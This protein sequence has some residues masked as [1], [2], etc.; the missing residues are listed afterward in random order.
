MRLE[1][2]CV[3]DPFWQTQSQL[4]EPANLFQTLQAMLVFAKL[5]SL[6]FSTNIITINFISLI[7]KD[8]VNTGDNI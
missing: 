8:K 2:V 6:Q 4:T 1:I 3:Q 5:C 7:I